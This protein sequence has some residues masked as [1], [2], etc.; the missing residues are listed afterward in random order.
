MAKFA[1]NGFISI[2]NQVVAHTTEVSWSS[3]NNGK[4]Q[5]SLTGQ[6]GATTGEPEAEVQGKC[7]T[8]KVATERRRIIEAYQ[9]GTEITVVYR[10]ANGE[11]RA[12]GVITS[13]SLMSRVDEGDEFDFTF[14]GHED[15]I[16]QVG[17]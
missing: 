12:K 7:I 9:S 1:T 16:R 15:P 4:L 3:K 5:K 6:K 17:A 11:L 8:P 10:T 2:D 13:C 14:T